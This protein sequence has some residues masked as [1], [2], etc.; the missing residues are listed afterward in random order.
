MLTL[1]IKKQR[2]AGWLDCKDAAATR[3]AIV[4]I[5]P[6]KTPLKMPKLVAVLECC[7]GSKEVTRIQ[8]YE[9]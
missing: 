6:L 8:I 3:H 7:C 1:V 9:D 5:A 4:R 2:K